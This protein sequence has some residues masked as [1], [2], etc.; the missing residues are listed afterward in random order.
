MA[1]TQVQAE[2][3]ATNAI[4]GT[5]IADN[6]ITATH[7]A[8]NSISGT[9]VQ[10]GGIV[11]TMI[12]A[13]NVTAAKIVSDGVET[14]H[15]HSNVISGQSAVTAAS[16]DYVLIGD[17]SDSTNLKK[18]LVSGITSLATISGISSSADATAIT[19]GSDESVD[20]AKGIVVE[21]SGTTAGLYLNGTNSD[22]VAQGNFVRYGTNF[23]TQSDSAN[24]D[25]ITYAFNGSTFV[26][27][28]NVKSN[29]NVGIGS[30]NPSSAL[31]V[32]KSFSGT[33][34]T[35]HQT[36]GAS[37]SD[38]GLDV[39]TS[40]TGTTVQRWFNS[41]TELMRVTGSGTVGIGE[42]SPAAP[43][44]VEHSSGTAFDSGTEVTE[45]TIIS[46]KAGTDD[47][48][49][50]NYA[51]LGLHV[52][53]GATSQGFMSY[54]R[55]GNNSGY[56]AFSGRN[57]STSYKENMRITSDGLWTTAGLHEI[58]SS[59][60]NNFVAGASADT[61]YDINNYNYQNQHNGTAGVDGTAMTITQLTWQ[62]NTT[63]YGYIVRLYIIHGAYSANLHTIYSSA[64]TDSDL[65][66]GHSFSRSFGE[67][68]DTGGNGGIV[69]AT[70]H[71][72]I[73]NL[74]VA[75]RF[76]NHTATAYNPLTLLIKTNGPPASG[77]TPSMKIWRI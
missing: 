54:V 6:A 30:T 60:P 59:T 38:R 31:H 1:R 74:K 56:F 72:D 15:L 46:N 24:D 4:S 43:L 25:L 55:D 13:N 28:L 37:S 11:T 35:L 20:F 21:G 73:Q 52:A 61:W 58:H 45:S 39:E 16:G 67:L 7:I 9:L 57:G 10:D 8:T 76:N 41:G 66:S 68:Y 71:T 77:T 12:A 14:R 64:G 26:N 40:S 70:G 23:L 29:G 33:L 19:I 34:V 69:Y 32:D 62:N 5:I 36:A 17:T 48:G 63:T 3:I 75:V 22:S 44:H 50:N 65:N 47:S 2:L 51:S 53:D 27:A 42:T 49:V 18:V